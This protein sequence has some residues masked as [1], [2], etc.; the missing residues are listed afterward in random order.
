MLDV[1]ERID[2]CFGV[3]YGSYVSEDGGLEAAPELS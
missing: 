1:E 3:E 2:I